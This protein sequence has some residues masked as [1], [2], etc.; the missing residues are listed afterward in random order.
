M[1]SID[2]M[3]TFRK[4]GN[5]LKV[6][7]ANANQLFMGPVSRDSKFNIIFIIMV[8]PR[9]YTII[10][11]ILPLREL[12]LVFIPFF[13]QRIFSLEAFILKENLCIRKVEIYEEP[14][15]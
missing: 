15:S 12:V 14:W 6:Q 2:K 8:Y 9:L 10:I 1:L 11:C 5:S 7:T 13:K 4:L 3:S